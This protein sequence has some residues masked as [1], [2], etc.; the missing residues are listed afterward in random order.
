MTDTDRYP[1]RFQARFQSNL[2]KMRDGEAVELPGWERL[3]LLERLADSERDEPELA[4]RLL[5]GAP[6]QDWQL[7]DALA[8]AIEAG[9]EELARTLVRFGVSKQPLARAAERGL[10]SVVGAMLERGARFNRRFPREPAPL[11][12]AAAAGSGAEA[13]CRALV[14]AGC[15]MT[16]RDPA[17]NRAS[18]IAADRGAE[19]LANFLNDSVGARGPAWFREA[20]KRGVDHYVVHQ[21]GGF[22]LGFNPN[23][24]QTPLLTGGEEEGFGW[25]TSTEQA[26]EALANAGSLRYELEWFLP[27]LDKLETG[28]NFGLDALE[29]HREA[30]EVVR[31]R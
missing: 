14:E 27:F 17:G 30:F 22:G 19:G 1:D 31:R 23:D 29:P 7:D 16:V 12:L 2:Q 26:R 18:E 6:L 13:T 9:H 28:E 3:A 10:A 21:S 4:A 15:D 25:P 11:H 5:E 24:L 8:K 20:Q